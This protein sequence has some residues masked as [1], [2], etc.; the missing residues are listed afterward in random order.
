MQLTLV[1][2]PAR[3]ASVVLRKRDTL[4]G[5]QKGC[6]IRIPS[7]EVSRRHCLLFLEKGQLSVE[8]LQSANGTFV[9]GERI[10]GKQKIK[11]GDQLK[12]GPLTFRI[13]VPQV[14]SKSTPNAEPRDTDSE[15]TYRFVD[16]KRPAAPKEIEIEFDPQLLDGIGQGEDLRDMLRGMDR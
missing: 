10:T 16:D 5:R 7:D 12:V 1:G 11:P 14:K 8:D 9:N 2:G 3:T 4:V 15:P 6:D 13:D